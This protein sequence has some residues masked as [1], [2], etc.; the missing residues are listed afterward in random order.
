MLNNKH[1]QVKNTAAELNQVMKQSKQT[2]VAVKNAKPKEEKKEVNASASEKALA[3]GQVVEKQVAV[4]EAGLK[5]ANSKKLNENRLTSKGTQANEKTEVALEPMK[6]KE[7]EVI[8]PPEEFPKVE[9]K[10]K[11][12]TEIKINLNLDK[13]PEE[14]PIEKLIKELEEISI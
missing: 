1:A 7:L 5:T 10:K 4:K 13:E 9:T 2:Q 14:N 3:A 11:K 8:V 6:T 12:E